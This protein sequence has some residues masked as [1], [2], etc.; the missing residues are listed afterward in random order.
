MSASFQSVNCVNLLVSASSLLVGLCYL[1]KCLGDYLV[2]QQPRSNI[3]DSCTPGICNTTTKMQ[4]GGLQLEKIF[5]G[6]C[7]Q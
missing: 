7:T 6:I 5:L 1:L 4:I 2:C 3:N